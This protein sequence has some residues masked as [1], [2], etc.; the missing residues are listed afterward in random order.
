M[1]KVGIALRCL[2][3]DLI[4]F[5]VH[6]QISI[7]IINKQSFVLT[8]IVTNHDLVIII[9]IHTA[10][11]DRCQRQRDTLRQ[12]VETIPESPLGNSLLWAKS[13]VSSKWKKN[14]FGSNR[15]KPKQD[16]FR[17][18]FG[19]FRKTKKKIFRF[20]SV[21]RTFI[22]TTETN[23]TVSKRTETIWNFLINT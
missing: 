10:A 15:N 8:A 12:H 9:V 23:R 17:V 11:L 4:Q 21:F 13:R 19:L 20:V 1:W 7:F 16:L 5:I 14:I 2:A 18:C 22:E 6:Q 3:K